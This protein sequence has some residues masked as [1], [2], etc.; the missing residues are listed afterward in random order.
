MNISD[1]LQD[2]EYDPSNITIFEG[3]TSISA[4]INST[5]END[6]KI[7]CIMYDRDKE[8][9]LQNKLAFLRHKSEEFNFEIIP[10]GGNDIDELVTGNSHGGIIALCSD[11]KFTPIE[12]AN[13]SQSGFYVM[14][15]GIEDPY[16]FGYALRSLYAA[17]ADG[18]I[19]PKRNWMS[20]AG[21]VCRSSAGASEKLNIFID[22]DASAPHI[23]KKHGYKIVCAAIRNSISFYDADFSRPLF[24]IIGGE[25]RG[26]SSS[27]LS[28]ADQIV[29][30]DYASDFQ[31]SLST[32]SCAAVLGFEVMRQNKI[33]KNF[34]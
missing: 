34:T 23:L 25:K 29:R 12:E 24:L 1:I 14:L 13:I 17:G 22:N 28:L 8:K 21:I 33:A 18:I 16:N 3:M 30:I 5:V 10:V 27:T 4:I 2:K 9:N 7:I 19:V 26:I 15:E 32:A 31:G 20:A 11:R 6:R